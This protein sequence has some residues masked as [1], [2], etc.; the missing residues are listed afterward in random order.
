MQFSI[1]IPVYN[2]HVKTLVESLLEQAKAS[3]L[4]FE[5]LCIDDCSELSISYINQKLNLL[6][7]VNYKVLASNIGRAAIRNLLFKEA[8]YEHCII[9]DCDLAIENPKFI[10]NYL[11]A[12]Q[13]NAILVGGHYY[14]KEAPQN[15]KEFLHW[16]Y[17]SS[18]EARSLS[19]RKQAP[20]HSFMSSNFACTKT[21]F[22]RVRFNESLVDY[23]H[24]DSI[25]AID[26]K[27]KGLQ[28][29]HIDNPVLHLGLD[30]QDV[31]LAKQKKAITNLKA[32]LNDPRYASLLG[33]YSKLIK[34]S[35][36]NFIYQ[37]I[38][39]F[40]SSIYKNLHSTKPRLLAL[41]LQKLIWLKN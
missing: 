39:L 2:V 14:N 28:I 4:E 22:D 7:Q 26:A 8:K 37:L 40:E 6:D 34:W 12:F 23:G 3:K 16:L 36:K 17:G 10:Q 27:Q 5:I 29:V 11:E 33:D 9:L 35:K 38:K 20:Y 15:E 19:K 30:E 18:I 24:E 41:Q 25:F 13:D 32:L 31:F 21:D 1:L